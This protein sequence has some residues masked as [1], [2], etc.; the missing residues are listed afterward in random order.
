MQLWGWQLHGFPAGLCT[1]PRKNNRQ[2]TSI[3]KHSDPQQL[4]QL[5][6]GFRIRFASEIGFQSHGSEHGI[7]GLRHTSWS[8]IANAMIEFSYSIENA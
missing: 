5:S 3:S 2:T 6:C 7:H 4:S 1:V 8:W